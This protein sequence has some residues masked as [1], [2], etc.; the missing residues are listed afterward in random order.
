MESINRE[1][2]RTTQLLTLTPG[3]YE[4]ADMGTWTTINVLA[5]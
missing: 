3:F 5:N 4:T 1:Y 2:I